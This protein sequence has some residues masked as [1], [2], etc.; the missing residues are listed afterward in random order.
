[1]KTFGLE[2]KDGEKKM[3]VKNQNECVVMRR[4][5]D[6]ICTVVSIPHPSKEET[7]RIVEKLNAQA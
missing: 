5:C 2:V 6:D 1:M 4:G 7:Q 3:V